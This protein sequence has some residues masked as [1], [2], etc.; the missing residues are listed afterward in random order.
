MIGVLITVVN[1]AIHT[2]AIHPSSSRLPKY[3]SA[4]YRKPLLSASGT[5]SR[6]RAHTMQPI[7]SAPATS[8]TGPGGPDQS[9]S[10]LVA[11]TSAGS[12]TLAPRLSLVQKYKPWPVVQPAATCHSSAVQSGLERPGHSTCLSSAPQSR[13]YSNRTRLRQ[14]RVDTKGALGLDK[15]ESNACNPERKSCQ[16]SDEPAEWG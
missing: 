14:V 6:D 7:T 2:F 1:T 5:Q 12:P 8:Q 3:L 10:G 16:T 15:H 11:W 4:T 9:S 13:G